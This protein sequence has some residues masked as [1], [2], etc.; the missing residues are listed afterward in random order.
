MTLS[1][2]PSSLKRYRDLIALFYKYGHGDLV[3]KAPIVDDP[4]PHAVAPPV[5]LEAD[6]FAK[7]LE[8]LG[9]TYIKLGQLLSTRADLI[10]AAYMQAL[11][12]LQDSA[13][14][15]PVENVQDI[16]SVEIGVRLNKAFQEFDPV[17]FA[18]ASLGQ[19]HHAVLRSGQRV[20]VKVQRPGARELVSD[21]LEAMT[22]LAEFLDLHT[23]VG[24]RYHFSNIVSELRKA[25]LQELDYRLEL[26]NLKTMKAALAEFDT[27]MVPQPI[28]DYSSGR[29]LTME[30]VSGVKIT[31]MS[32]LVRLELEGDQLAEDLFRA[33]LHQ[34]LVVGFFHADPHPGNVFLTQDHRIALLDLGMVGRLEGAIQT[35][36]LKLLLAIS[37][38]NGERAAETAVKMGT[39]D[40]DFDEQQF[41]N[42]IAELVMLQKERPLENL[43]IGK[44]VM[45]VQRISADCGLSVPPQLTLLGKT[46]LNL[47]LVGRTLS[48]QFNPNDS[49]RRNA[50]KILHDRTKQSLAPANL[51]S[52]LLDAKE[53]V[54]QLPNRLNQF[55][56]LVATNKVRIKVDSINENLLTTSFQKIANRITLGLILAAMIVSASLMMRVDTEFRILGY[57]GV[58]M[59]LFI[60]AMIGG[61]GLAV[62]IVR[63]DTSQK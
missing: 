19:V 23:E 7:D 8:K 20:V 9:P 11:S 36:L 55:I 2:R 18:T 26:A 53:L 39:P 49:I 12:R 59:I 22:E 5:P 48:P 16:I 61:I 14:P 56:E 10:P 52:V 30:Y 31:K 42:R 27:I 41:R 51:L 1:L 29:V 45:D 33:Y 4:L 6:D 63:S 47:D 24:K 50:A 38:G 17:P 54:E 46:L 34:I 21:D 44:V 57:P 58:G 60:F 37:E 32:R 3:Q 25:L 43:E 40:E 35:H 62:Q 28:E 15:V 13:D